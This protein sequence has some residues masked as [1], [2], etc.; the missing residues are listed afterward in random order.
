MKSIFLVIICSIFSWSAYSQ[1]VNAPKSKNS[2]MKQ[3][4]LLVRIPTDYTTEQAKK[5]G[6]LWDKLLE[7][8]KSDGVYI[9]S[10]AFPGE[11]YTVTGKEK[12]VSKETVLSGNLRVVS[13]IV[14][15]AKTMDEALEL[16]KS[17]PVLEYG[18]K[19][20]VRE[21]PKLLKPVD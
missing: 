19:I 4:S 10:F 21:I 8:W 14:L 18:G 6:P 17:C 3:F 11:S 20:E 1:S 9:L 12:S 2:Q 7:K 5:V 15:Q 16:A 13:N